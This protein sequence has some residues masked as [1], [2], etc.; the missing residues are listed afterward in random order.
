MIHTTV[1][2]YI[3]CCRRSATGHGY[4]VRQKGRLKRNSPYDELHARFLTRC[5][6]Q[7]SFNEIGALS[8][9]PSTILKVPES[10]L[11]NLPSFIRIVS[12][13]LYEHISESSSDLNVNN[14]ESFCSKLN[15][16]FRKIRNTFEHLPVIRR[17]SD[18][19]RTFFGKIGT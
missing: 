10:R 8:Q 15:N 18:F 4:A 14:R 3:F 13:S 5:E 6:R 19:R 12:R 11:K 16:I 17:T 9:K 7:C 2:C 1:S